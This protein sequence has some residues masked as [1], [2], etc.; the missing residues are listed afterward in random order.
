MND[1]SLRKMVA[2][3]CALDRDIENLKGLLQDAKDTLKAEAE[4]RPDEQTATDGGGWSWTFEGTDGNIVRVT[5]PGDAL[6]TAI[7]DEG[8][9]TAKIREAA[10][11]HFVR[12][13]QQAP[14]WKLVPDFRQ[15]AEVLLGKSAAKLIKLVS[16]AAP[17]TVSFE[18]K[19][20]Q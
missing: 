9:T 20:Q 14:K 7:D 16:K 4:S 6:K 17:V 8:K 3:A 1:A 11:A 18:T 13:F 19:D 15:A 2:N 5:R 12:L 10:G